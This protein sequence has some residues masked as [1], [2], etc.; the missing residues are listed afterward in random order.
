MRRCDATTNSD[1]NR[2]RDRDSDSRGDSYGDTDLKLDS[3]ANRYARG[4]LL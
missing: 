3:D 1:A 2:E 4:C